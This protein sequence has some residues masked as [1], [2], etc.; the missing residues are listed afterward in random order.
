VKR[1]RATTGWRRLDE[2]IA[3]R[4][5]AQVEPVDIHLADA[6]DDAQPNDP[7]MSY[8]GVRASV[9]DDE[10]HNGIGK[11]AKCMFMT[12]RKDRAAGAA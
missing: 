4:I 11:C 6:A 1:V 9:I 2:G 12:R 3:M 8:C 7:I 10:W 5:N